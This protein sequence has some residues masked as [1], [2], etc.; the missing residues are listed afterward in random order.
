MEEAR[1][2][3]IKSAVVDGRTVRA[4]T[5]DDRQLVVNAPQDLWMVSDLMKYG[6]IVS[7]SLRSNHRLM[8]IFVSWFPMLLLIAVWIFFMRQM[9]GGGEVVLSHWKVKGSHD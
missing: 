8:S 9:Q 2:G 7:A 3:A 6:V 1:Q 5:T 4:I